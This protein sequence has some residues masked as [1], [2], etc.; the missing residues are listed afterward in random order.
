MA[1]TDTPARGTRKAH[2]VAAGEEFLYLGR[3]LTP[4][5]RS[6]G[7]PVRI[8]TEGPGNG[9]LIRVETGKPLAGVSPATKFWAASL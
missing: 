1:L 5:D 8:G 7:V 4:W 9:T 2:Q 3:W 6:E